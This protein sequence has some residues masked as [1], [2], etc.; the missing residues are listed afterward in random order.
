[1]GFLA[2]T[3]IAYLTNNTCSSVRKVH[4]S[5]LGLDADYPFSGSH[6]LF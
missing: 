1:M 3:K 2:M 6:M 4:D 5:N